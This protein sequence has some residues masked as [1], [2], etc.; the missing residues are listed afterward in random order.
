MKI[1]NIKEKV[2]KDMENFRKKNQTETKNT[3][4]VPISRRKNLK[5][6][7][8]TEIKE[9]KTEEI[10][11]NSRAVKGICKNSAIPSKDQN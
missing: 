7:D 6:Q 8:K 1:K 5:T 10:S 4:E 11:N 2:T 9:K 3:V